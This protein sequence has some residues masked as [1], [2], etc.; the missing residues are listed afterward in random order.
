[1]LLAKQNIKYKFNKKNKDKTLF[2]IPHLE[3]SKHL[4]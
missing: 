2:N 1:M 4:L 3:Q